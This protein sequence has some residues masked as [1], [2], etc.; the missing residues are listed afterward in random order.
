MDLKG[1]IGM[2]P[3]FHVAPHGKRVRPFAL[4]REVAVARD[5]RISPALVALHDTAS[6]TLLKL[7]V[8]SVLSDR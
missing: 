6:L 1:C 7:L 8:P 2:V 5:D 4:K 3:T